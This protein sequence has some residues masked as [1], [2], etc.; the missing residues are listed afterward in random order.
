MKKTILSLLLA[1]MTVGIFTS[2]D[3]L[4]GKAK[5]QMEKSIKKI[6]RNPKSV[7]VSDVKT[8]VLND[9][10]CIL[11]CKVRAENRYGGYDISELEYYLL[12]DTVE[13]DV[14]YH[15]NLVDVGGEY[16][17][18]SFSSIVIDATDGFKGKE[19]IPVEEFIEKTPMGINYNKY[20]KFIVYSHRNDTAFEKK[21]YSEQ[22][23]YVY[24]TTIHA[25]CK[26]WGKTIKE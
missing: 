11:S 18:N 26:A 2:C 15:E 23:M 17:N 12:K 7:N 19:V 25:I 14:E 1:V 8:V 3:S 21:S 5:K 6:A 13:N 16:R 22:F 24:N 10:L 9:T 4:E 20:V